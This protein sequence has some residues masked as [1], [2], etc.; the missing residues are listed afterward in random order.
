[1]K[2]FELFKLGMLVLVSGIPMWYQLY[3]VFA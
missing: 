3:L 2:K 1:M